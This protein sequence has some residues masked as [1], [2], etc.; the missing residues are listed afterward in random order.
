MKTT[1]TH[2]YKKLSTSALLTLIVS[3]VAAPSDAAVVSRTQ[4]T[5]PSVGGR[6]ATMSARTQTQTSTTTSAT[7]TTDE[8]ELVAEPET[9][10]TTTDEEVVVITNKSNQFG[11]ELAD[12][13]TGNASARNDTLAEMIRRQRAALDSADA[14]ATANAAATAAL[15]ANRSS[16]DTGLRQCMQ[17]KCGD[18]FTKCS[19]DGDTIWGD[20]M[21]TCRRNLNCTGEEYRLFATE[22][23]ADRDL[24]AQ[25]S[26]YNRV[27]DC[28]ARYNECIFTQCGK[29][30]TKCLGKSAGDSAIN[31][32]AKIAK[33]CTQQDSGL[34]SRAMSVFGTLR[35]DAEKQIKRDEERL[36]ELRDQMAAQCKKFGA[37]F[38]ERSF[39]CVYT[40][41][42]FA[43]NSSTPYASKKAY[44]G[45]I[46]S[47]TPDWFGID[48][49]TFK[50]NAYRLTREQTSATS[51]FLGSGVG[52]AGGALSS[53]AIDRAIETKKAK[54]A[55]D[56]AKEKL[57]KA[58]QDT[59][60]DE[61]ADEDDDESTE[62]K[63]D[64]KLKNAINSF[65]EKR[66]DKKADRQA[67]KDAEKAAK[68]KEIDDK[69]KQIAETEALLNGNNMI[70]M[71]SDGAQNRTEQNRTEQNSNDDD[72]EEQPT[73]TEPTKN[74]RA[75]KKAQRQAERETKK[76][77]KEEEKK[78]KKQEDKTVEQTNE[79]SKTGLFKNLQ[80]RR[81]ERQAKR[82][83]EA[84]QQQEQEQQKA[85]EEAAQKCEKDIRR[86]Y[87]FNYKQEDLYKQI[88][89]ELTNQAEQD[90]ETWL[91][92]PATRESKGDCNGVPYT[93][94]IGDKNR[95]CVPRI[96]HQLYKKTAI[97]IDIEAEEK[98][99]TRKIQ[100]EC[101]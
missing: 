51:A 30:F 72:L 84:K 8:S 19:G 22:I 38:D 56:A 2:F 24:N 18:D 71:Q 6:V 13:S 89:Q 54:N 85:Q 25:L 1:K 41:N 14:S 74:S 81:N 16:C 46:F 48:I 101:D 5:R 66:A 61:E 12:A 27:L 44:A 45:S 97:E 34:A 32:C 42:F 33:E 75:D 52:I 77:Q 15:A 98:F 17:N 26:A 94:K 7:T 28:G 23:K 95:D 35:V 20:K 90:F 100:E 99:I 31:A 87:T 59:D 50:E 69:N 11:T 64:G 49:T 63:K 3:A 21:D 39:D 29:T 96:C 65:K 78:N 76:E 62:T 70:G 86:K 58:E 80:D 83:E 43:N 91:N 4:G 47:C 53:G 60:T 55:L 37:M 92:T 79:K 40:V 9:S 93:C 73:E 57:E 67:K 88:Y 10:D 82:D 36:Y 68:Q